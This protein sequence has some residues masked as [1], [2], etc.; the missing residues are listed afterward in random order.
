MPEPIE[1]FRPQVNFHSIL[2]PWFSIV[3]ALFA[4]LRQNLPP[5]FL[6]ALPEKLF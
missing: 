6:P 3:T 2:L 1:S 5:T 4:H